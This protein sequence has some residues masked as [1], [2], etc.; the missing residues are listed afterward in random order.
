MSI[1]K[2][3]GL[4]TKGLSRVNE[5]RQQGI[6]CGYFVCHYLE[7]K[8]RCFDGQGPA[9][10]PWPADKRV[11]E[12][13]E[14]LK[15]WT[16]SLEEQWRRWCEQKDAAAEKEAAFEKAVAEAAR[17]LLEVKGLSHKLL[18]ALKAHA[19]GMLDEGAAGEDP[20]LPKGFGE[21]PKP[22]LEAKAEEKKACL[23]YTSPSPRDRQK[24][25][26]PSSA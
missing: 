6:E 15:N 16:K 10:Q 19:E 26:M 14:K 5:S 25:R 1:L 13:K 2:L 3:L 9:T 7:D 24:S 23:L 11:K 18:E 21:K 4:P 20:P 22:K 17:K 8:M 12:L